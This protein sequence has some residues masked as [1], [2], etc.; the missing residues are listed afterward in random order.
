MK[1]IAASLLATLLLLIPLSARPLALGDIQLK[2][3]LNAPLDARIP[4]ISATAS[5]IESIRV[6]LASVDQFARA[7]VERPFLLSGLKFEVV[8]GKGAPH[9]HVTSARP[10]AEPFLNFLLEIDWAKGRALREYTVLLDPPVY[11]AAVRRTAE[12]T[13]RTVQA[14]TRRAAAPSRARTAA[15]PRASRPAPARPASQAGESYRVRNNDTLWSLAARFR[16][17]GASI[18]QTM[19]A[20]LR[21]NPEGFENG[22]VNMMNA[23]AVLRIPSQFDA[24]QE[25]RTRALAEVQRQHSAWAEIRRSLGRNVPTATQTA[26]T[27]TPD[28]MPQT[29]ADTPTASPSQPTGTSAEAPATSRLKIASGGE[30]KGGVGTSESD[31]ASISSLR[32]DLTIAQEETDRVRRESE[33]LGSKLEQAEAVIQELRR[34]V[35][36][37]SDEMSALQQKLGEVDPTAAAAIQAGVETVTAGVEAPSTETAQIPVAPSTES[38]TG[39]ESMPASTEAT[40]TAPETQ[41]GT[42][43][44]MPAGEAGTSESPVMTADGNG[45]GSETAPMQAGTPETA[46]PSAAM[47]PVETPVETPTE[48]PTTSESAPQGGDAMPAPTQAD[49]AMPPASATGPTSFMD[50]LRGQL[51]QLPGGTAGILGGSGA[52]LVIVMLIVWLLRRRGS[53]PEE[54][55]LAMPLTA[56]ELDSQALSGDVPDS[57]KEQADAVM[58]SA[59]EQVASFDE[60]QSDTVTGAAGSD[61]DDPLDEVNVY[62]AYERFEQ[63]EQLVRDAIAKEPENADYKLKLLEVFYSAKDTAAFEQTAAELQAQVGDDSPQMETARKWWSEI[64][65]SGGAG[66]LAA[67]AAAV[68]AAGAA[69]AALDPFGDDDA[70]DNVAENFVETTTLSPGDGQDDAVDFDL[71]FEEAVDTEGGVDFDLGFDDSG[72]VVAGEDTRVDFDL[73]FTDDEAPASTDLDV[74][75]DDGLDVA[76]ETADDT[77]GDDLQALADDG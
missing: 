6:N 21:L 74:V 25:T 3:R 19:L 8:R 61:D 73:D 17:A 67:G 48:A 11:G 77:L 26:S 45:T 35:T 53:A 37:Q 27:G 42:A 51:D 56:D 16:P 58:S 15:A 33:E 75:L 24:E 47:T 4:L 70:N 72:E 62:L 5:D 65:P 46:T 7:G 14:P 39:T 22:N 41:T 64:E 32:N 31:S 20:M 1:R 40:V 23:G 57:V 13:V 63:A 54:D 44:E 18:Q 38:T 50:K 76:A 59:A 9:I 52:L 68:A 36:V 71:G 66:L 60:T 34:L 28:A 12:S 69:A 30:A 10:I 2:S 49:A 43:P 55:E 29:S